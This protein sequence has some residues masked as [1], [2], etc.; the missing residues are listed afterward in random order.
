M[1]RTA[2]LVLLLACRV[3]TAEA[4]SSSAVDCSL[5]R[6]PSEKLLCTEESLRKAET[7]F[8]GI[9]KNPSKAQLQKI[10]HYFESR[11]CEDVQQLQKST[12]FDVSGLE[13]LPCFLAEE[14]PRVAAKIFGGCY[15]SNMDNFTPSC[16][17]AEKAKAVR[18]LPEFIR[19]LGTLYGSNSS[20]CGTIRY[21]HYR[22]QNVAVLL[23]LFDTTASFG[24]D[25]SG[26][27]GESTKQPWSPYPSFLNEDELNADSRGHI[28]KT[29]ILEN[30]SWQGLWERDTVKQFHT[31]AEAARTG[32][33]DYYTQSRKLPREQAERSA[34]FHL[35]NLV[36]AYV[37][38][39]HSSIRYWGAEEIDRFLKEGKLPS[40]ESLEF[41]YEYSL[42]NPKIL[43]TETL[44]SASLAMLLKLAVLNNFSASDIQRLIQAGAPVDNSAL[45]D[46]AL[47]SSVR[48]PEITRL[49]L[50]SGAKV[51]AQNAFGKTALM[52]AI[53]YG[54]FEAVELL[55]ERGADMNLATRNPPPF[56]DCG[57]SI[58][59]GGR[60]PLM[61]AAWHASP[62]V[63]EFLL[64]HGAKP[65]TK[66]SEEND[67]HVYEAKNDFR[68]ES[69]SLR[70]RSAPELEEKR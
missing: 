23:A 22:S 60:T 57:I 32:L 37:V 11:S 4:E 59:V 39:H 58:S 38:G 19:L 53:Q 68:S 63:K 42:P 14:S 10:A 69:S 41:Q 64:K 21:G 40:Q 6:S 5:A 55:I 61:Y 31:L 25:L 2:V 20:S 18:G 45:K 28:A 24:S 46:T 26:P 36:N 56:G 48:R 43:S 47:M 51:N 65:E 33:I 52:Y 62:E 27:Q 17:S 16:D 3:S 30:F 1:K 29:P 15:G 66:D 13:D 50:D 8:P 12:L 54:S 34:R 9:P 7:R 67:F 35:A 44:R 70:S 49:L